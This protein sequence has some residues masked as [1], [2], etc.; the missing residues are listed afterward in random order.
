MSDADMDAL[1]G[2]MA[3]SAAPVDATPGAETTAPVSGKG[4]ILEGNAEDKPVAAPAD[5]P[6]DWRIKLAGE[7]K[8]YLKTLDRFNSPADLAKAYR[9]AQQ[10][11][12]SGNLR[13]ALPENPTAEELN[14]WR[15]ENGV[16]ETADGYKFEVGYQWTESDVPV[17][18]S[19]A[20]YA[21]ENNI[22]KQY[23]DKIASFYA[24]TQQRNL[25]MIEEFDARSHQQG[26]DALRA[27]WGPEY[28][29]NINAIK[30]TLAAHATEDVV[31]AM[32]AS[33]TPDGKRWGDSPEMLKVF[34]SLAREANPSATIVPSTGFSTAEDEY[35][36][37]SKK[38]GTKEYWSDPKMQ[39]RFVELTEAKE[40]RERKG[41]AA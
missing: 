23:A 26:E 28:R 34:A 5:W 21:L 41:R 14:A 38:V 33:R 37:L 3:E 36:A 27:E 10:R 25:E 16:P 8:S 4:T 22:P 6:E 9:D 18:E 35:E 30:N 29:R 32:L 39:A 20:N 2:G 12:S 7:D 11:L 17:L 13:S 40:A 31:E 15:A 24:Q 1:S 19:F